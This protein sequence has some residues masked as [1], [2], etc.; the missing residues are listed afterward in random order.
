MMGDTILLV[1]DNKMFIE[2]EKEFL[3]YSPVEILTAEDGVE[4]LHEIRNKRPDL[5]FM[6]IFMPK[7]DGITCCQ[8][9]KSDFS[10]VNIPVVIVTAKGNDDEQNK[11][12]FAGCDHFITKPLDRDCFLNVARSFI[13]SINRRGKRRQVNITAVCRMNNETFHCSIHDLGVGGAFV[14]TSYFGIPKSVIHLSFSLPDGSII[15][16]QGRIA[17]VNRVKSLKPIGF[18]IQFALLPNHATKA[19]TQ[20]IMEG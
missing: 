13:S 7:M 17:W 5:V 9:I 19:I 18:G 14:A 4:A 2:I 11:A 16:C 3:Q 15:E 10:L 8:A 1:D 6:D 20:F 12:T